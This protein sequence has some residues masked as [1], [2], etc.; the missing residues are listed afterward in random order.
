MFS[1]LSF[2]SCPEVRK[3]S[4][5]ILS[6]EEEKRCNSASLSGMERNATVY[7]VMVYTNS[8]LIVPLITFLEEENE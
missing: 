3:V 7:C 1:F 4:R 5:D 8:R 2:F 6:Q